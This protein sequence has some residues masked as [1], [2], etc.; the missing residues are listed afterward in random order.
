MLILK[1][2]RFKGI[3]RFVEE[4]RIVLDNFGSLI[5]VDG[6]NKNTAGSSGAA[7]STI[8]NALDFLF[9]INSIPNSILQSRLTDETISVEGDFDLNGKT[10]LIARSKKLK[11]TLDGEV[12][13]G[14][15]KLTEEKLDQILGI[16]RHLFRPMLHKVQGERGFFLNFTPKETN[17]FLTDCLGLGRFKKHIEDLEK[18]QLDLSKMIGTITA[19][20][21]SSKVS[22]STLESAKSALGEPPKVSLTQD[23]IL[24]L[25]EKA[26]LSKAAFQSVSD[27]HDGELSALEAERPKLILIEFDSSTLAKLEQDRAAVIKQRE[28]LVL[29]EKDRVQVAQKKAYEIKAKI[30]GFKSRIEKAAIAMA[31]A[32]K[33]SSEVKKIRENTCFTCEQPWTTESA[34]KKEAQLLEKIKELRTAVFDG[35]ERAQSELSIAEEELAFCVNESKPSYQVE[36]DLAKLDKEESNFKMALDEEKAK[37]KQHHSQIHLTNKGKQE[38]FLV[39]QKALQ[40]R[41]QLELNQLYG[42]AELDRKALEGAVSEMKLYES[43]RTR[44]AASLESFKAQE[45]ELLGKMEMCSDHLEAAN[46]QAALFEE[47]RNAVKSYLSCSFDDALDNI[48]DKATTLIRN[49]PNMA[50]AT[51]QLVGIKETKEGKVKEEVNS[52]IHVDGNENI[53]I[54]SLSGGERSS[55]DLAI[56]ISV[57][58]YIEERTATGINVYIMD[59]PFSG[60]DSVNSEAIL[61]MLK[62]SKTHK[63]IIIVDHNDVTKSLIQ[64]KIVVVREG[65]FSKI[66]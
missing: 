61:N 9:G 55:I 64:D 32:I 49:I 11:I 10:L 27:R 62:E 33:L 14:S 17:D 24:K 39:K 16:P 28:S 5:Q 53:P 2:L 12:T 63:K 13:T 35:E 54:K 26:D 52:L 43:S 46:E 19:S 36:I 15:S 6:L 31:E 65:D 8:F 1:E 38:E 3:G 45:K 40:S 37:E 30:V 48:S 29:A 44:Y 20:L 23:T 25:K 66:S 4:Q 58:D 47:L 60:L 7:K 34:K 21:E 18:K 22:F 50:N 59:E 57:L 42:Q 41:H 56:D 51:I